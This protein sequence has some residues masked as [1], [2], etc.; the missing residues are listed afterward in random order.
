MHKA[1]SNF[2]GDAS[3]SAEQQVA[4]K[5]RSLCLPL[6]AETLNSAN[7]DDLMQQIALED[8][9]IDTIPSDG[10][11]KEYQITR[12]KVRVSKHTC[13]MSEVQLQSLLDRTKP[14]QG[15]WILPQLTEFASSNIIAL[16]LLK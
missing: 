1:S 15:P 6:L 16:K 3:L 13:F 8:R 12:F 11:D 7:E 2:I 5:T 4:L 10:S 14:S 9:G